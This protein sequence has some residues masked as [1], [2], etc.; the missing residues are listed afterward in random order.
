[1]KFDYVNPLLYLLGQLTKV[2]SLWCRGG[3][4]GL[5]V[6]SSL[7]HDIGGFNNEL[8]LFEDN[9]ILKRL[10]F[11]EKFKIIP[12]W[13]TTS[14]RKHK[15]IGVIKLNWLYFRLHKAYRNGATQQEL[16]AMYNAVVN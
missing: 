6:L 2:K 8:L 12:E 16:L 10:P 3:D 5:F 1:M 14:A 15:E 4:Q 9:E 7:F 11:P 13:L